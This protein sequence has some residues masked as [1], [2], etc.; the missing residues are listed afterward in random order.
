MK[1]SDLI[2]PDMNTARSVNL[3]RDQ[4]AIDVIS[5]YRIT[6]KTR[7]VLGRF[8]DS[9]QGERVTA[10]SLTGPYGMGKSA[11]VNYLMAI[12]GPLDDQISQIAMQ[13]LKENDVDLHR[14]LLN[15]MS[16]IVGNEG[17]F[18]VFVT[19]A[20]EPI[21]Y[22]LARGLQRALASVDLPGITDLSKRLKTIIEKSVIE[23]SV[24]FGIFQE[25]L[26]LIGR[27][28]VIVV[29]EFGKNLEYLAHHYDKGDLF[30][31]QQLAEMD[32]V[33]LW[34][35][36]HQAFDEYVLGLSTVQSQEWSKIQGR[37][38][39]VSFMESTSQMLY[40]IRKA[41]KQNLEQEQKDRII[42]WA[43]DAKNLID[44][45]DISSKQ[46]FDVNTIA[47]MYPFHPFTAIALI[48]LCRKFAQN[49]RTLIS[50]ICSGHINALSAYLERTEVDFA[51]EI[52]AM[53]LDY[54]YDY[55]FQVNT[56]TYIN[57]A[58]SQQWLEI[59]DRI[60]NASYNMPQL[61]R[62]ILKNIGVINLLS[63]GALGVKAS[64]ENIYSIMKYS[65]NVDRDTVRSLIDHLIAN[66][67]LIYREY[68]GEYRLWEGSDFDVYGAIREKKAKL[69]IVSIDTILQDY[70]PLSPV[71]ASRHSYKTGTVRRFERRW[72]NIEYL[73]ED[74]AP[75]N[76]YDGLFLYS[77]GTV[78]VPSHIPRRCCDGRPLFVAYV[79]SLSTIHE[80]ALEVAAARSVLEE[81]PE[82]A[83]DSV[84]R[85]EVKFRIKVAE[86]QFLEHISQ[87]YLPGSEDVLWYSNGEQ[88]GIHNN[89]ELSTNLSD[90]FDSYYNKCPFIR[91]EMISYE[92]LSNVA[93]RARRELVEAMA[94]RA[95]EEQ[96]GF[97]GFGPEVAVYRSLLLSEG[98]HLWDEE[99]GC[100]RLSLEGND[101][102]LRYVWEEISECITNAG[103]EGITVADIIR[104]LREPPFG[105]RQG[106]A[107][108]Y[109]SLYLLVKSDE[110]A[111]FRERAYQPY[112]TAADMALM[113]KRPEL[114]TLK[115]FTSTN[116][117]REV[118]DIYQSILST[119]QIEDG[120]GLRNAT[121]LGVVGPLI[122]FVNGLPAYARQ[123]RDISREAQLVRSAILNSVD[124]MDLLFNELPE[125]V[126]IDL[127]KIERNG[128]L[129]G[130]ILQKRLCSALLELDQAYRCLNVKVQETILN[131]FGHKNLQELYD[132]QRE[133][134]APLVDICDDIGLK[135]VLQAFAREYQDPAEWVRGIAGIVVKKPMD[136]WSDK[137]FILFASKLRDYVDR[138]Q[139][140][141]TL[142]SVNGHLIKK[143]TKLFSIM[144][145]DGKVKREVIKTANTQHD[146]I[147][148]I[149]SEIMA[150]PK[151]E[152]M[153][154]L[155]AVAEKIFKGDSNGQ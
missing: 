100:W 129:S 138:I 77:F 119:A 66:G 76:G 90:L 153:A 130:D 28:M 5:N 124:P 65:Y 79:P 141:E 127:N 40:L 155:A 134:I 135:S 20:Y 39:D 128:C 98:L 6:A 30:I 24:V 41:L 48:E 109:I 123:T 102:R 45:S 107:P 139:Q 63:L 53:G 78:A 144:T 71:I 56:T 42:K 108:I 110:V 146:K 96:L 81:S 154:V 126:E 132:T 68:A 62:V 36:L 117:Q 47:S 91:N 22:T 84:A 60:N 122:K 51:K 94:T 103:D 133:R 25:I 37:F 10:W 3:E 87:M 17:F 35:C 64:P 101:H 80:L 27:P 61:A 150:L 49:D 125:A 38:E 143:D 4:G 145:S 26:H 2:Y 104:V 31:I 43:E 46:Q 13:K 86:Q 112:L 67:Y 89:R 83:H 58:E 147:Q 73:T 115:Q 50:F 34:V 23:S 16:A 18:R 120:P 19:A 137:D 44:K 32:S 97:K 106:P 59:H 33:Y 149:V 116:V 114:F 140:L 11:F 21:N 29:D 92:N 12:T 74:L 54:L 93:V 55:F 82:L 152:S 95:G 8:I 7:E 52:P 131:V 75:K 118:F 142:V 121:M 136:S 148:G 111:V 85:K 99:T 113:L 9:L 69:A 72:L 70:M 15:S 57:R 105:M 88:I 1:L 14:E 151:D